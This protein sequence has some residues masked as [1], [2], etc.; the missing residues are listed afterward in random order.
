MSEALT[1]TV[2]KR[3]YEIPADFGSDPQAFAEACGYNDSEEWRVYRQDDPKMRTGPE[4]RC[5]EPMV[6][7][8]GD[9]F[10]IIPA[11]IT[12]G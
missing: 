12:G 1:V 11:Y 2:N 9:R 4:D 5:S 10:V 3:E 6:V 8:D 7:S